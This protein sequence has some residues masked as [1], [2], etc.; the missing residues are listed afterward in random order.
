[1]LALWLWVYGEEIP[2][3]LRYRGDLLRGPTMTDAVV[4]LRPCG[5]AL[6]YRRELEA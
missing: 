4:E 2:D 1:M 6:P 3:D 5:K